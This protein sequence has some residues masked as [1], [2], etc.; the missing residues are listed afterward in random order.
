[1]YEILYYYYYYYYE[2]YFSVKIF[3]NKILIE[4]TLIKGQIQRI[5]HLIRLLIKTHGTP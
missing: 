4:D 3:S 5:S 1:M 2:L